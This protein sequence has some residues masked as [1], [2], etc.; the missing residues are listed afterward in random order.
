MRSFFYV[1][2]FF[3]LNVRNVSNQKHL[4]CDGLFLW[5]GVYKSEIQLS[6]ETFLPRVLFG[7]CFLSELLLKFAEHSMAPESHQWQNQ[8]TI[9]QTPSKQNIGNRTPLS[10]G[11]KKEIY[12]DV[13]F[14]H[15]AITALTYGIGLRPY[16]G[17]WLNNTN[18]YHI[19]NTNWV[20]DIHVV[21][22]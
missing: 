15:G 20:E 6:N 1:T 22:C 21:G 2:C 16:K 13:R 11:R 12:R 19:N 3:V 10:D 17:L 4:N 8:T 5:T 18:S 9:E 7:F 14:F